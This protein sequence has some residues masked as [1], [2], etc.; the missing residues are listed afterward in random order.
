[1]KLTDTQLVML[2]A[3]SQRKDGAIELAS[4]LKGST[5]QNV[6]RK[7]LR[8]G[9]VEEVP[10]GATLPVWRRGEDQGSVALRITKRGR[11]VCRISPVL[12]GL[13]LLGFAPADPRMI[14]GVGDTAF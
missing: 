8:A 11:S 4:N 13:S 6:V 9:L 14:V 12:S 10:A 3:A 2:C 5:S 1:M 7:L